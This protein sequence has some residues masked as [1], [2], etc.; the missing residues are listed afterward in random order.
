MTRVQGCAVV[1]IGPV[2]DDGPRDTVGRKP[3]AAVPAEQVNR[4]S[5]CRAPA[6][7]VIDLGNFDNELSV[8][9]EHGE[10]LA[11]E[12]LSALPIEFPDLASRSCDQSVTNPGGRGRFCGTPPGTR[13]PNL[14]I[15]SHLL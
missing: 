8:V 11:G 6:V 14:V 9:T 15:K 2:L 5:R 3:S 10:E 12:A 4:A 7:D 13:T 1:V